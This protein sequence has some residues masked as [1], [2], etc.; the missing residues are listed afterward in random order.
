MGLV[1]P[2]WI[3]AAVGFAIVGVFVALT[4][5]VVMKGFVTTVLVVAFELA[6]G[7]FEAAAFAF[8]V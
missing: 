2:E 5:L 7:P 3:V 6:L 1:D 8:A 4:A